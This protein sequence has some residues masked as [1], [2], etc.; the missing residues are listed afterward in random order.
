M[1]SV[2]QVLTQFC[3]LADQPVDSLAVQSLG[4][5]GG[6]SGSQLFRVATHSGSLLLRKLPRTGNPY[7]KRQI[8]IHQ[9]IEHCFQNGCWFL[10]C[11]EKSVAG[12]TLVNFNDS[13]WQAERWIEGEASYESNPSNS[14]LDSIFGS[15]TQF[16][17][18]S[19]KF[20]SKLG[21]VPAVRNRISR[22]HQLADIRS[23]EIRQSLQVRPAPLKAR[24]FPL[25][26]QVC[27]LFHRF[28]DPVAHDL[29]QLS[30]QNLRL[31]P[32][33]RDIWH[34]HLLFEGEKLNGI[35]DYGALDIDHP[36][37][38][39]SRLSVSLASDDPSSFPNAYEAYRRHA[40]LSDLEV[41]LGFTLNRANI[42][43]SSMNWIDWIYRQERTF[44]SH[45]LIEKRMSRNIKHMQFLENPTQN[46][47]F[48][49]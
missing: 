3:C 42:L 23:E 27:E 9:V 19:S 11:P 48:D 1:N 45:E 49:R 15:L 4:N 33:F 31:V 14:K 35:V 39:I 28:R 25:A 2:L 17:E 41:E 44:D 40:N 18:I 20:S 21:P 22:L 7:G 46:H 10:A 16:H 37:T 5:N 29:N 47:L 6:F 12:A 43:M 26:I 38:D 34:D 8:W 30:D 24:L 36:A 32:C 13:L